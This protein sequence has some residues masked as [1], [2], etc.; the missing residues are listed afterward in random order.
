MIQIYEAANQAYE[1]N[2]DAV[3]HPLSCTVSEVLKGTWEMSLQNPYDENA[4]LIRSGAVI[5][6]DT[7]IGK[8]QLFRIYKTRKIREWRER[9]GLPDLL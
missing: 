8:G 7:N 2:G 3:L 1:K 4:G 5:K 9:L 6:A